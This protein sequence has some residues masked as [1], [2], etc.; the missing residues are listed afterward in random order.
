MFNTLTLNIIVAVNFIC[1]AYATYKLAIDISTKD[2]LFIL[3]SACGILS[4]S[5]CAI[6]PCN[7]VFFL[8]A[9][10]FTNMWFVYFID[11][12][13]SK[14]SRFMAISCLNWVAIFAMYILTNV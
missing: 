13:N 6:L 5:A 8:L 12:N 14:Y 7:T 3:A 2:L 10:I 11:Q 1:F 4:L 9:F